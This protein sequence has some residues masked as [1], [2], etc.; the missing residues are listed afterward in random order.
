MRKILIL[1]AVLLA[2]FIFSAGERVSA[3]SPPNPS[4]QVM[5]ENNP[6]VVLI[7]DSGAHVGVI[8]E[9][10]AE[11]TRAGDIIIVVSNEITE[12]SELFAESS[13]KEMALSPPLI[14]TELMPAERREKPP[15]GIDYRFTAGRTFYDLPPNEIYSGFG[16]E[17]SARAK[18]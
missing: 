14:T 1:Y 18:I 9:I 7:V 15:T 2:A 12:P 16:F 11:T 13:F 4:E 3:H 6:K 5:A 8:S 10:I 17:N